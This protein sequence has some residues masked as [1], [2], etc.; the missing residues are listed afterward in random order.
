MLMSLLMLMVILMTVC[1]HQMRMM[2]LRV[3]A[4]ARVIHLTQ[5]PGNWCV[6][7]ANKPG[8]PESSCANLK[9]IQKAFVLSLDSWLCPWCFITPWPKPGLG[10]ESNARNS[11]VSDT[12]YNELIIQNKTITQSIIDLQKT[13]DDTHLNIKN[14]IDC[15]SDQLKSYHTNSTN[16]MDNIKT[17]FNDIKNSSSTSQSAESEQSPHITEPNTVSP[18]AGQ[19]KPDCEP[20]VKYVPN[21]ISGELKDKLIHYMQEN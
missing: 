14:K 2:I 21:A 10:T 12:L 13:S 17:M 1:I 15:L 6:Q 20:Y 19:I 4:N 5:V 9:G 16:H 8:T 11:P 3:L 7:N 18:H